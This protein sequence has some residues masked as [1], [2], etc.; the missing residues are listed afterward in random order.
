M[1]E[2]KQEEIQAKPQFDMF[3]RMNRRCNFNCEYCF[4]QSMDE[5]RRAE[6]PECGKY[7]AEH[8]AQRFGETGKVW[9]IRM[10]GGE[11]L[12][13]PGFVELAKA[14]TRG[15][16]ISVNTNL[17]TPNAYELADA[18]ETKRIFSINATLHILE[19][20]KS[21]DGMKEYL[22]KFL[23]FQERGFNIWLAYVTYPP[24]LG[25]IEKD[26]ERMRGEGVKRINVKMFRGKYKGRR[27]PRDYS[28]D[29]R[30]FIKGL[31]L[32][33]YEQQILSCCA[34]FVGKKC[35]AGY[36]AFHMDISGNVTRCSTLN[37]EYGNLFD[38]TFKPGE[39]ARRC[40][41]RECACPYQGM[42]FTAS[43]GSTVPPKIAVRA[44]QHLIIVGE[45]IG[46]LTGKVMG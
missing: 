16:Y 25:R 36:R 18:V 32:N 7:S 42:N 20:E 24:L 37:D 44:I 17:S 45:W 5:E 1:V 28:N 15:H 34:S 10:T 22:R 14:L 11:P 21:K 2:Q 43:S 29:E 4:Q 39:S 41:V 30:A 38:G 31:V 6:D 23:Y 8:I 12:L 46:G 3:W 35:Q 33:N 13:Y 27:Y 26:M 40:S 19:R 9:L